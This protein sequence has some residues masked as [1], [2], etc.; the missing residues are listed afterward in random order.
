[1]CVLEGEEEGEEKGSWLGGMASASERSG[2]NRMRE[3]EEKSLSEERNDI[4]HI[5]Q[6]YN[7][8]T[9]FCHGNSAVGH[10]IDCYL[11]YQ[12]KCFVGKENISLSFFF[13][14]DCLLHQVPPTLRIDI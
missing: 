2:D 13:C 11:L 12:E 9:F 5:T 8:L 1:M 3:F 7:T 10:D 6:L 4:S 14:L